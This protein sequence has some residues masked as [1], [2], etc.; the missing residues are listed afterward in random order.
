MLL[1]GFHF[2]F[3][4]FVRGGVLGENT[5]YTIRLQSYMQCISKAKDC[6][7]NL[8]L[9]NQKDKTAAVFPVI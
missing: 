6:N 8:D 4:C 2:V 3:V 9:V 5:Q 7:V 1:S